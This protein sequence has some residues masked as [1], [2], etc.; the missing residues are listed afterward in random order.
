[1]RGVAVYPSKDIDREA[2]AGA[3]SPRK[4]AARPLAVI[5]SVEPES[6]ADDAGFEP[7]CCIISVDGQ[8]VRDLIDWRWLSADDEIT[9]GYIDLDGDEGEVELFRDEGESW[10]FEFEGV[11]FDGVKQCRN[12]CIFCFMRQLPGEMRPS[13]TL[14]DDDFRLSFLSGTFVTFTNLSA[15]DEAR[16][17]EQCISPLRVSLHASNPDVRRRIIGKHAQHGIDVLD[18]LLAH[19]IEFHVQ[20]VLMPGENDGDVLRET[21]EWAYA[22]PGILDVCIVPLGFTK[23]QTRFEKSFDDPAAARAAMDVIRPVQARAIAERGTLW[24]F[25]ADEFYCNAY[26]DALIENLPPTEHYGEFDMFEDGVGIVRSFVDDWQRACDEGKDALAASA[27]EAANVRVRIVFGYA[28][29]GFVSRLMKGS[30]VR[31]FMSPLFVENKFFGGNVDVTG[32]LC[33]CDII[34]AIRET[35]AGGAPEHGGDMPCAPERGELRHLQSLGSPDSHESPTGAFGSCGTRLVKEPKPASDNEAA[36]CLI[37]SASVEGA[38]RSSRAVPHDENAP[39]ER[40]PK[41]DCLSM[42]DAPHPRAA[43]TAGAPHPRAAE[44]AGQTVSVPSLLFAIPRVIFNDDGVTLD[45]MTIADI[46]K[47][48]GARVAVVSCNGSEFLPEI[49]RLAADAAAEREL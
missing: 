27:L 10:G 16:I 40:F 15:E 32:L 1:M 14:R 48:T 17:V 21:L 43:E 22:R 35:L 12:A 11:V 6:P 46:E 49:A 29:H 3:P 34:A 47:A 8:P 38:G 18:R 33:G 37:E 20:I 19:G 45:D 39:V 24:A 42:A 7:G 41:Q 25:A 13:L 36:S 9:V 26:G 5:E 2:A 30:A 23:H 28:T 44:T 31:G 4:R